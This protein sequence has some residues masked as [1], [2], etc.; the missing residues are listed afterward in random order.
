MLL[1][2]KS[3]RKFRPALH[4]FCLPFLFSSF[5][6]NGVR[7]FTGSP[8]V[9]HFLLTHVN[10]KTF[11]Y[12]VAGAL[13]VGKGHHSYRCWDFYGYRCKFGKVDNFVLPFNW[14]IG[15]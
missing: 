1:L 14:V 7:H 15:L 2:G 4:S 13:S 11:S 10:Y 8:Q 9:P 12:N 6:S 5:Y 3:A